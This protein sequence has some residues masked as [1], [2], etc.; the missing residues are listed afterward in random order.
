M[1]GVFGGT[2]IA[3]AIITDMNAALLCGH[4]AGEWSYTGH[5]NAALAKTFGHSD[6]RLLAADK[7]DPGKPVFF[8]GGGEISTGWIFAAEKQVTHLI[9]RWKSVSIEVASISESFRPVFV[10]SVSNV[11]LG[12][13]DFQSNVSSTHASNIVFILQAVEKNKKN[14]ETLQR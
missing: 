11:N 12:F 14:M 2:A 6:D 4:D 9:I 1:A 3:T 10:K 13:L 8:W 7:A 5:K